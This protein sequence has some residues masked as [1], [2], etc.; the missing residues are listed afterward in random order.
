MSFVGVTVCVRGVMMRSTSRVTDKLRYLETSGA[1]VRSSFTFQGTMRAWPLLSCI[2][3]AATV[4]AEGLRPHQEREFLG[5]GPRVKA[6]QFDFQNRSPSDFISFLEKQQSFVTLQRK[7][8]GW[9]QRSDI[10]GLIERLDSTAPCVPVITVLSSK[11]PIG[12]RSTVGHE[13]HYLIE[14]FKDG[15]FPVGASSYVQHYTD[16]ELRDWWKGEK[17]R[18]GLREEESA[19]PDASR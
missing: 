18:R 6:E 7:H 17:Q 1:M 9:I 11:L 12:Q 13:I 4:S 3:I 16:Q 8:C 2:V 14:G 10:D 5:S 15:C 19:Q